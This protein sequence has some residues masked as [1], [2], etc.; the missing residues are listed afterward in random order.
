MVRIVLLYWV[1][2]PDGA[3]VSGEIGGWFDMGACNAAAVSLT[4][5]NPA[6]GWSPRFATRCVEVPR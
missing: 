4:E 5:P 2:G 6:D 3:I 1:L